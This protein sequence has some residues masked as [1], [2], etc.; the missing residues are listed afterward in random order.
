[1]TAPRLAVGAS[2]VATVRLGAAYRAAL[3]ATHGDF[4]AT[5]PGAYVERIN[6][7][8]W[9]SP[10]LRDSWAFHHSAYLHG[11]TQFLTL[12]PIAY[13]DSY[14]AIAAVLLPVYALLLLVA[15]ALL[16]RAVN[17]PADRVVTFWSVYAIV[18]LFFPILQALGQREFEIVIVAA[19]A[20]AVVAAVADRPLLLGSAWA[21]VTGFKYI[22]VLAVLY[23]IGRRWW[24]VL[25]AYVAALLVIAGMAEA[26]FGLRGFFNDTVRSQAA[27][28]LSELR[29]GD[30]LCESF[31]NPLTQDFAHANQT[32]AGVRWG[33]CAL[34]DRHPWL[35]LPFSYLV[36]CAAVGAAAVLGFVRLERADRLDSRAE[37]W[38]RLLE[39]S[40]VITACSTL[41]FA[42]YYYLAVL[43]VPLVVLFAR[44]AA[45]WPTR[46][47][48]MIA[49]AAAYVLLGAF[50]VPSGATLRLIGVDVFAIYMRG[51]FYVYGE[52]LLLAL[53]LREYLAL[54][55]AARAA[56][57][58]STSTVGM[59]GSDW[60]A[61]VRSTK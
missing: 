7:T 15:I 49:W 19:L 53:L 24:R 12:Y 11:P 48:A 35:P 36:V 29:S 6:P 41:F 44:F 50:V 32:F 21:Y 27:A 22:P 56:T 10:D 17:A 54:P 28:Q 45:E 1:M 5:L 37:Q 52:M 8:L 18:G 4:Y 14:R 58:A 9:N 40:V 57:A 2:I 46:R 59:A 47:G 26:V 42:H 51:A 61:S 20:L 39:L 55:A 31:V 25:L 34:R 60:R 43:V 3:T 33:L 23:F 38:R 13:L 16:C 30:A